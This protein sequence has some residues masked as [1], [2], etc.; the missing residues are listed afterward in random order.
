MNKKLKDSL[1]IGFAAFA[2]F[3][4]AGNIIFPAGIGAAAGTQWPV[5]LLATMLASIVIPLLALYAMSSSEEGYL[6]ACRPIGIWYYNFT[7]AFLVIFVVA[8]AN[9]PRTAATTHEMSIAPFFPDFPIQATVVI[10]FIVAMFLSLDKSNLVDRIGK[11]MT[12][13]LLIMMIVIIAKGFITPIGT[14][15]QTGQENVFG[16]AFIELYSTGDIY[17]GLMF[18]TML[19]VAASAKE[20]K[21]A[22]D[23]KGIMGISCIIAVL[24]ACISTAVALISMCAD[25]LSGLCKQKISY[26][27]WVIIVCVI[28][29]VIGSMGVENIISFAGPAFLTV[30]PAG[31]VLIVVVLLGKYCPNRGAYKYSVIAALI[32]GIIDGLNALGVPGVSAITSWLP[33]AGAGFAWILPSIAGF[34]IGWIK[35]RLVP[36][37][38][39]QQS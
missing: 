18:S 14:V 17:S 2:M 12:P 32:C 6:G 19:V 21:N 15:V 37:N 4:G 10:Y 22:E 7:F 31:I 16:S 38:N 1:V 39:A 27:A 3:F 28:G 24:F 34:V 23:R 25:F 33:F 13:I 30:F 20:Y 8:L 35:Y 26:K 5:A 29:C 9:L 36:E 11:F